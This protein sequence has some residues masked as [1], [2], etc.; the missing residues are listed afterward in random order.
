MFLVS[1]LIVVAAY[2]L[3]SLSAAIIVSRQ[4][5]MADPRTYGSGNPGASNMLR[6]GNKKAAAYTLLGDA[7]K[8]LV[9][10]LVARAFAGWLDLGTGVV[11]WSAIAVVI[12]HMWPLFFGFKGGKGV[13]TA[14][15]VILAMSPWTAFW[16]IAVWLVIAFKF[17]QS[18]LAALIAAAIAPIAGFI[19]MDTPS[20]GWALVVVAVL[21]LY[22]HKDNIKRIL[23]GN[24]LKIGEKAKPLDGQ[25]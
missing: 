25:E 10:V 5:N 3:G 19:V 7:L 23:N 24:E 15:G 17:K 1:I 20:W 6:S 16:C 11:A 22:R 21:V 13:A 2:L 12:G 8:G 18:S 4:F 9:A 14:L